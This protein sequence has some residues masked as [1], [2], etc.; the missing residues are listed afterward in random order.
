MT[1][2]YPQNLNTSEVDYI[3]FTPHQYV[4]NRDGANGPRTGAAVILYMPEST[5]SMSNPNGWGEVK[6]E[7]PLGRI[8]RDVGSNLAGSANNLSDGEGHIDRLKEAIEGTG[9]NAGGAL[10]QLG[11][12]AIAGAAGAT[13]NQLLALSTG[14][15]YNPNI[16]LLYKGPTLRGFNFQFLFAPKSASEAAEVNAI[17]KHF[18]IHSAP[19]D[20]GNGMFRVPD[21]FQVTY[22]SG[23]GR[24]RNMNEFKRAALSNIQVQSNPGLPSY[25]TFENGMPVLTAL[26][27]TFTEMDVILRQDHQSSPHMPGF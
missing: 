1:F 27:M 16:E 10:K 2:R 21:V 17:I 25:S 15:V 14:E 26:S 20:T 6:F 8:V 11:V 19:A 3:I 18:K 22:M 9:N 4:S 13:A 24:N 5:P 7:G 23:S 12:Q